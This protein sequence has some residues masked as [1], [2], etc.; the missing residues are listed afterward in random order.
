MNLLFDPWL[1]TS[2]GKLS[3]LEA[4]ERVRD[5][6]ITLSGTPFISVLRL[7]L[8]AC[9]YGGES[10]VSLLRSGIS[11]RTLRKLER[12]RGAF[13]LR[14]G[15]LT[16]PDLEALVHPHAI[17]C[18]EWPTGNTMAFHHHT[19]DDRPIQLEDNALAL[20]LLEFQ[21]FAPTAGQSPTGYRRLSPCADVVLAVAIGENLLETLALNLVP[22]E[23]PAMPSWALARAQSEDFLLQSRNSAG[24]VSEQYTWLAQAVRLHENGVGTARGFGLENR[25]DPMMTV[26]TRKR[27]G[28]QRPLKPAG[29]EPW[30]LACRAMGLGTD[31]TPTLRHAAA[32]GVP[33]QVRVVAQVS[34]PKNKVKVL[35][36][37]DETYTLEQL[38]LSL[39][40]AVWRHRQRL[41][42]TSNDLAR[43]FVSTVED[44]L[45]KEGNAFRFEE[46]WRD[47][48]TSIPIPSRSLRRN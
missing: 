45:I 21:A 38:S 24:S 3:L 48:K 7:Q 29:I 25:I 16:C 18:G 15:Y 2:S 33:H 4:L 30:L 31:G 46:F 6:Q 5:V 37:I 34:S 43:T 13:E 23:R 10:S 1:P 32:L 39:S 11:S 36:R 17:I 22:D 40:D 35:E 42:K 27:D 9:L 47:F 41:A 26:W 12:H 44:R 19:R 8:A 28:E 14:D 20:R